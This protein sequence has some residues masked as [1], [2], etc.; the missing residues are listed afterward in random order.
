[1]KSRLRRIES[2]WPTSYS[3]AREMAVADQQVAAPG[4]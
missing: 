1:M 4:L 3:E 2:N